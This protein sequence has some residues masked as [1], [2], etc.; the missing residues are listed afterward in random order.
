M[1]IREIVEQTVPIGFEI[2]NAYV[3]FSEMTASVVAVVTEVGPRKGPRRELRIQLEWPYGAAGPLRERMIPR[4][5]RADPSTP[6]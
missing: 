5:L 2:R 3:D 4:L 6:G 1:K